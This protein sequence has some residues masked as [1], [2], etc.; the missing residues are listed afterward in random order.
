VNKDRD[1]MQAEIDRLRA[2]AERTCTWTKEEDFES[3]VWHTGCEN[4][5][6]FSDGGLKEN[7]TRFC[8]YCGGKIIEVNQRGGD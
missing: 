4:A 5:F 3:N 7:D 6:Y 2:E 8:F 1:A